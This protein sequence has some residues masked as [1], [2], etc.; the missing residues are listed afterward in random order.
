MSK[1]TSA[2]RDNI[3]VSAR[4]VFEVHQYFGV[5]TSES[6]DRKKRRRTVDQTIERGIN[7]L[8]S[9]NPPRSRDAAIRSIV[10]PLA[11]VLALIF[12]QYAL[13]IRVAGWL[14]DYLQGATTE[15]SEAG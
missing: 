11:F 12:P 3:A 14:W 1:L 4:H 13:A 2:G 5:R 15:Q 10:G 9:S 8:E 7:V 6:P